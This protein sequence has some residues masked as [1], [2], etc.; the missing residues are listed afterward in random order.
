MEADH[1]QTFG[2]QRIG[3]LFKPI[4]GLLKVLWGVWNLA[5]AVFSAVGFIA[6]LPTFIYTL[7]HFEASC[8]PQNISMDN[9]AGQWTF[10]FIVSKLFELGDSLFLAVLQKEIGFLHWYHHI[11]IFTFM[12]VSGLQWHP[13]MISGVCWN[14]GVHAIMYFYY[15]CACANLRWPKVLAKAVTALQITQMFAQCILAVASAFTCKFNSIG[16]LSGLAMYAAYL[17]LFVDFFLSK[18]VRARINKGPGAIAVKV[19]AV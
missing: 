13:H 5:T 4:R 9:T 8:S 1:L 12:F 6:V 3:H 11:T 18:Y 17:A 14:Y 15:A 10:Y 16:H 2:L 7:Q 19:K